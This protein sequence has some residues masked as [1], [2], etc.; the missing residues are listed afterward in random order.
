M[1]GAD[2]GI[3]NEKTQEKIQQTYREKTA[4]ELTPSED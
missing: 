3:Q 2:E 1:G 4:Q